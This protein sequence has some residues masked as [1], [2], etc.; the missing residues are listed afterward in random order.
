MEG[1]KLW[2]MATCLPPLV[3]KMLDIFTQAFT[4]LPNRNFPRVFSKSGNFQNVSVSVLAAVL[5]P[6]SQFQPQRQA[7]KAHSCHLRNCP[8]ESRPW[9]SAFWKIPITVLI[10]I[11]IILIILINLIMTQYT[12]T[13]ESE[14][15]GSL[16]LF[17]FIYWTF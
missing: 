16:C 14:F 7:P 6:P 10:N 15:Y 3:K 13:P 5:D 9:E 2:L 8:L 1:E 12:Y 11:E 4:H 17:N